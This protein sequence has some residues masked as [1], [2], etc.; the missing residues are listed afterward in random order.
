MFT[1]CRILFL[2]PEFVIWLCLNIDI[3]LRTG[4]FIIVY[5]RFLCVHFY[6]SFRVVIVIAIAFVILFILY[7]TDK[8]KTNDPFI[9][10][11]LNRINLVLNMVF[12]RL[13]SH[14]GIRENGRAYMAV[15]ESLKW[16]FQIRKSPIQNSK[17]L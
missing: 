7:I 14:I 1:I 16:T 8:R 3:L 10:K 6:W 4:F 9:V 17:H 15:K 2:I 5:K 12:F 11:L 13:L